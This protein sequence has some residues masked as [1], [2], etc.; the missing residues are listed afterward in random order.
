MGNNQV[1]NQKAQQQK[2]PGLK[3]LNIH[4]NINF[5][6]TEGL[7]S[8]VREHKEVQRK[9]KVIQQKIQVIVES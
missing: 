2:G 3:L 6:K 7:L 5:M 1:V 8:E 9:K 4:G